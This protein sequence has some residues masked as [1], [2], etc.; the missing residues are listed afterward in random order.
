MASE[1]KDERLSVITLSKKECVDLIGLLAAQLGNQTLVGNYSG[2]TPEVSIVD[3]GV[4]VKTL[5][6]IVK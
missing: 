5:Y 6:F 2:A 4:R 3:R 1:S